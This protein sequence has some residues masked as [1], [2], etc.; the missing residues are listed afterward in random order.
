MGCFNFVTSLPSCLQTQGSGTCT[1][2]VSLW[3]FHFPLVYCFPSTNFVLQSQ[4]DV[5]PTAS[6]DG[7]ADTL[8]KP[9]H[10]HKASET[11]WFII[12]LPD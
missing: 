12:M 6:S 4:K 10:V 3:S 11:E 8:Y 2:Q 7:S 9:V 1:A 5:T